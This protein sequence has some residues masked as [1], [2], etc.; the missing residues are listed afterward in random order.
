MQINPIKVWRQNCKRPYEIY[1]CF[2]SPLVPSSTSYNHIGRR[3]YTYIFVFS[4][5]AFCLVVVA[6]C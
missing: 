2:Y 1:G 4:N 6:L 3:T 5:I